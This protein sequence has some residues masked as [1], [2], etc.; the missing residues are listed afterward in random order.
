[1]VGRLKVEGG[2][3]EVPK[4]KKERAGRPAFA[5]CL[6]PTCYRVGYRLRLRPHS[7]SREQARPD[8]SAAAPWQ[9]CRAALSQL[10]VKNGQ[11]RANAVGC[12]PGS[13]GVSRCLGVRPEPLVCAAQGRQKGARREE[14]GSGE[15]RPNAS[16][17]PSVRQVGLD[18][19]G[20]GLHCAAP[21]PHV[22][23]VWGV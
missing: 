19:W 3:C 4:P 23:L 16:G 18:C 7:C 13:A 10:Q 20:Q 11:V 2:Q 9:T 5:C 1:M 21:G 8:D 14:G 22:F 6:S 12:S 17:R 15:L